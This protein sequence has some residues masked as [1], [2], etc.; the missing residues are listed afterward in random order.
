MARRSRKKAVIQTR[1]A[2]KK[3]ARYLVIPLA[4]LLVLVIVLVGQNRA[5]KQEQ[6]EHSAAEVTKDSGSAAEESTEALDLTKYH[7]GQDEVPDLT[8]LVQTYCQAKTDSDPETL[9]RVFGREGL[10]QDELEAERMKLEQVSRMVEGY[11]NISC[12]TVE[13]LEPDTYVVYPYFDIHYKG[14]R[15]LVPS[16][17]WSYAK[18]D[19][20]G[21]FY[22]TMDLTGEEEEHVK[23]VSQL[24][25]VKSLSQ[26]VKKEKQDAIAGD[27]VLQ[28]IYLGT[29][30]SDETNPDAT[31]PGET[32]SG[33]TNPADTSGTGKGS[34]VEIPAMT[35]P[36]ETAGTEH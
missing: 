16:L 34:V 21:R 8:A 6:P 22:L 10:S 18:K 24:E 33:D 32:N 27:M 5:S 3:Y 19:A 11:E 23:A 35:K 29:S 4:L 31:K 20:Q 2:I 1:D 28:Q 36:Q 25:D 12:Y 9:E 7:L 26:K 13:G 14:A 15:A 30:A 17:T